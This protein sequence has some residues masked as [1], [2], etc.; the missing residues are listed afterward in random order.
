MKLF[1]ILISCLVV[2]SF[3]LFPVTD[4]D[5]W[6][7]LSEGKLMIEN[8][9]LPTTEVFSYTA[10]GSPRYIDS[11]A[12]DALSFLGFKLVGIDG[13]NI[14][15]AII[16]FFVF[17]A[18][19]FYL[20]KERILNLFSLLFVI[21]ALFSIRGFFSLRPHTISF[22]FFVVFLILLFK[23]K[24]SK[25]HKYIF[26][27]ALLQFAWVNFHAS[28]I[29]GIAI[30]FIFLISELISKKIEKKD[31]V[32]G[33]SILFVSLLHIFYGPYFLFRVVQR[34]FLATEYQIQIIE[35]LP[36]TPESFISIRGL[37]LLSL[38]PLFY[39]ALKQKQI[40]ILLISIFT[41]ILGLSSSRFLPYL[42]LFLC[43]A[44][45][46]YFKKI[47]LP[48]IGALKPSKTSSTPLEIIRA[49]KEHE[50][51]K[52]LTGSTAVFLIILFLLFVGVKNQSFGFGLG[53]QKFTYPDKAVEFIKK[54]RLLE[55]SNGQ[56]YNTYNF[57]GYLMWTLYPHRVFIDGRA[58]PYYGK[59]FENYWKNF[60]DENIWEKNVQDYNITVALMTLPHTD[61]KKIYNDSSRMF[62]KNKWAL[63]YYDD[64]CMIYVKRIEEFN[65]IIK[66][67]EYKIIESQKI[68]FA[69]FQKAIKNQEDFD[70]ALKEVKRG[71]EINPES[72]RLHFTLSCLY[73]LAGQND[74]MLEEIK[75]TIKINPHFRPAQEILDKYYSKQNSEI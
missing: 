12:F 64:A 26:S 42:V 3:F 61:G 10:Y 31:I 16:S 18:L 15:K 75:K 9:E 27:L 49:E 67:Y 71:L 6:W 1:L 19:L 69:Y 38:F 50:E 51:N 24:E 32:L 44:A 56:I 37:V 33:T 23:Y 28:F 45:P 65:E 48:N 57:G 74:K 5:I 54:E 4:F 47:P 39:F 40:D 58:F 36:P 72:Y 59:I 17:A 30:S 2:F 43:I 20:K 22:L 52:S 8:R 62:P 25:K 7:H 34:Y 14:L 55:K 46:L 63:I 68:D 21:L 41:L 66:K 53:L 70:N 29:F 13:I 73:N 35:F 60:E 11:W